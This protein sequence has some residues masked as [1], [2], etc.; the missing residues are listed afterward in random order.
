[1]ASGH[2][3]LRIVSKFSQ[4]AADKFYS[5][6]DSIRIHEIFHTRHFQR[7]EQL[8]QLGHTRMHTAQS[9]HM[10]EAQ[11]EA[12]QRLFNSWYI[13]IIWHMGY[14]CRTLNNCPPQVVQP[15]PHHRVI[16]AVTVLCTHQVVVNLSQCNMNKIGRLKTVAERHHTSYI[17]IAVGKENVHTV[18]YMLLG[19]VSGFRVQSIHCTAINYITLL[20]NQNCG[21]YC[22]RNSHETRSF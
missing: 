18:H 11:V 7:V 5:L 8:L 1:M 3:L 21:F 2:C 13:C 12:I 14:T 6:F 10:K 15:S 17:K 22:D 16:G 20:Q 4:P 19:L 9:L